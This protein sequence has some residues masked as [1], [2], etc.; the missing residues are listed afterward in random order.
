M[1][2]RAS[3]SSG[4]K[5]A[6]RKGIGGILKFGMSWAG[7]LFAWL[8]GSAMPATFLGTWIAWGL[9]HLPAWVGGVIVL[10]GVLTTIRD[11]GMDWEPNRAAAMVAVFIPSVAAGVSIAVAGHS[12]KAAHLSAWIKGLASSILGLLGPTF[13]SLIGTVGALGILVGAV[14][15]AW[16]L[17]SRTMGKA[18]AT[19]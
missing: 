8:A 2:R 16:I 18:G 5:G 17:A 1:A 19:V 13:G 9:G 7:Y 4:G 11:I 15:S 3:S 12:N 10:A 14:V 6:S